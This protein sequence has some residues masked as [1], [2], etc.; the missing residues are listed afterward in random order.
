MAVE[1]LH[2]VDTITPPQGGAQAGYG[3]GIFAM[4]EP[5]SLESGGQCERAQ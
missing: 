1:V 2:P 4:K 3:I 5:A